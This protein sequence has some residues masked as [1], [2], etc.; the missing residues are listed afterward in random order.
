MISVTPKFLA[1]TIST[2]GDTP[3][4][5]PNVQPEPEPEPDLA[6]RALVEATVGV[7]LSTKPVCA[8][9]FWCAAR[10]QAKSEVGAG[11]EICVKYI[12]PHCNIEAPECSSSWCRQQCMGGEYGGNQAAVG[13]I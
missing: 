6:L 2:F 1:E 3:T 4:D 7:T 13:G 9:K 8:T 10:H 5:M 12:G 11:S